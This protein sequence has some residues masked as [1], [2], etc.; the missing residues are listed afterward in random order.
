M[1]A[2]VDRGSARGAGRVGG[3]ILAGFDGAGATLLHRCVGDR[4]RH[5]GDSRGDKAQA[6]DRGGV[7]TWA[8]RSFICALWDPTSCNTSPRGSALA[9]V[10][11]R[12]LRARL[13]G[14][15]SGTRLQGT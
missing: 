15:A 9:G 14:V 7:G 8:E 3:G 10:A 1:V 13:R 5:T 2:A 4:E 11:D 6:G 12:S